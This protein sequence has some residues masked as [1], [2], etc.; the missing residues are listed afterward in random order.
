MKSTGLLSLFSGLAVLLF[1]I[2]LYSSSAK[3][4]PS[5]SGHPSFQSPMI[6][7]TQSSLTVDNGKSLYSIR[8]TYNVSG[9][10]TAK[11]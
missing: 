2:G 3:A 4:A 10:S 6:N 8:Y 11:E 7:Y 5:G 1:A 9:V